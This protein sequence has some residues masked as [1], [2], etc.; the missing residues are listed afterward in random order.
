MELDLFLSSKLNATYSITSN[1]SLCYN[2]VTC[3]LSVRYTS[4]D[5]SARMSYVVYVTVICP[6][7]RIQF[8]M[9]ERKSRVAV[10][11]DVVS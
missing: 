7:D 2:P 3:I 5:I 8:V 1:R 6:T 9:D 4:E 11:V 10:Q